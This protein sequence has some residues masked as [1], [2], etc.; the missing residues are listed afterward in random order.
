MPP[1]IVGSGK[2][3]CRSAAENLQDLLE[4][5]PNLL[6]DLLALGYVRLRFVAGEPLPRSA[7]REAFVVEQRADLPD[8]QDI[9]ALVIASI[10][11]PLDGFKLGKFLLP[12]PEYMGL[13]QA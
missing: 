4:F 13:Y 9:L 7:Y 6:D 12:V 3:R 11:P 1:V 10:T 2:I 5:E 8:D